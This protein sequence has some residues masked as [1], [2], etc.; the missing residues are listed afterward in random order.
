ML[1]IRHLHSSEHCRLEATAI[2]TMLDIRGL[3]PRDVT[4]AL[5]L[6]KQRFEWTTRRGQIEL[7]VDNPAATVKAPTS[8]FNHDFDDGQVCLTSG[9]PGQLTFS[10]RHRHAGEA[11][12]PASFNLLLAQQWARTGNIPLH[13]AAFRHSGRNI[14]ALGRQGSGK[15]TLG[16]AAIAAGGQLVSD[17]WILAAAP[18][19]SQPMVERMRNFIMLRPGPATTRL[20]AQTHGLR[21]EE[22]PGHGKWVHWLDDEPHPQL[23]ASGRIDEIWWVTRPHG[24]RAEASQKTPIDG[25]RIL[26][27]L[28]ESAMPL[29][30]SARF[31]HERDMLLKACQR[32]ISNCKC[33]QAVTGLDLIR[34]PTATLQHLIEPLARTTDTMCW[35]TEASA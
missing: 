35:P 31:P 30:F 8:V 14:L 27:A 18:D 33:Y 5:G 10:H 7:S 6:G 1:S 28:I 12:L 4:N 25:A 9:G 17:D 3:A 24:G 15:S 26:A 32:M 16:M 11:M 23:P 13:A 22:A 2:R 34:N 19:R 20:L 21:F 29:L